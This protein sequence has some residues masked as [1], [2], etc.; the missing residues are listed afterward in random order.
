MRM[1]VRIQMRRLQA[2]A[3]DTLHLP[4]QLRIDLDAT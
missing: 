1:F 4:R 3:H 2:G